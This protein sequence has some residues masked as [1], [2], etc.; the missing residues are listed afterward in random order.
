MAIHYSMRKRDR[1]REIQAKPELS[2][3]AFF[4]A[5]VTP[6]KEKPV[7]KEDYIAGPNYKN[8]VIQPDNIEPSTLNK[9][10]KKREIFGA[11]GGLIPVI[12]SS[13]LKQEDPRRYK[14]DEQGEIDYSNRAVWRGFQI[15]RFLPD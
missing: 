3:T 11:K 1:L 7:L 12:D 10:Q 5:I 9:I 2:D 6:K 14:I 4:P 15:S 8:P 13:E